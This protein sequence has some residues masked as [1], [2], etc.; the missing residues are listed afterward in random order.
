MG[1]HRALSALRPPRILGEGRLLGPRMVR[2]NLLDTSNGGQ[3][4][5]WL[6]QG[7]TG[8]RKPQVV[9]SSPTSGSTGRDTGFVPQGP[10]G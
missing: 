3:N 4:R 1:E 6:T 5:C 7:V 2:V 9:G 10:R 8:F